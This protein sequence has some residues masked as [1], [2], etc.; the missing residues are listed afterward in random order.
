MKQN[1]VNSRIKQ[2]SDIIAIKSGAESEI[3]PIDRSFLEPYLEEIFKLD[4][5]DF[6]LYNLET[7]NTTYTIQLFLCIPELWEDISVDDLLAII[8]RF[9]NP[10]SFFCIILFVHKYIEVNIIELILNLETISKE[11]K[12]EIRQ[13][14]KNQYP[15]FLKTDTD[16]FLFSK[17]TYG[18]NIDEWGYIKQ[19]FLLDKRVKPAKQSIEELEQYVNYGAWSH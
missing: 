16:M 12:E 2:L 11:T 18:E 14:I 3:F 13:Y 10:F 15:N 17:K 5:N 6:L 7:V 9:T 4:R 19:K 8:G 1:I